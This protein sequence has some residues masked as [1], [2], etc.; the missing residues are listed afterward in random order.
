MFG[1]LYL[2]IYRYLLN[3]KRQTGH[4]ET[5]TD[6]FT[7]LP[8]FL[9][10]VCQ[11]YSNITCSKNATHKQTPRLPLKKK[12]QSSTRSKNEDSS[13][14]VSGRVV[15]LPRGTKKKKK[16]KTRGVKSSSTKRETQRR[17]E[18][19]RRRREIR[20]WE[21]WKKNRGNNGGG[22]TYREQRRQDD[23]WFKEL[24]KR[25]AARAR[26]SATKPGD[27]RCHLRSRQC[28]DLHAAPLG[29]IALA[30]RCR[31]M[32]RWTR[33]EKNASSS[34]FTLASE[35]AENICQNRT[36]ELSRYCT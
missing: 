7:T 32:V 8:S 15:K 28:A 17:R 6:R 29:L 3:F 31:A 21:E 24:G 11:K 13:I 4:S 23:A 33:V 34:L 35:P 9:H 25:A 22:L 18:G 26:E 10:I 27:T 36:G 19:W 2:D 1:A 20:A 12:K 14:N 16:K 5:Q 30:A